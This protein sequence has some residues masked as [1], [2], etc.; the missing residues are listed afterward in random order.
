[1][2]DYTGK[3]QRRTNKLVEM[4]GLLQNVTLGLKQILTTVLFALFVLPSLMDLTLA[5]TASM[6]TALDAFTKDLT[7]V[8]PFENILPNNPDQYKPITCYKCGAYRHRDGDDFEK[9]YKECKDLDTSRAE[10]EDCPT[11]V[12]GQLTNATCRVTTNTIT[13]QVT[14]FSRGC[15]FLLPCSELKECYDSTKKYSG[16][17]RSCCKETLCNSSPP[18]HSTWSILALSL[19]IKFCFR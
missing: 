19:L 15:S 14:S 11:F 7:T 18:T 8:F 1:M 3:L 10:T 5:H 6:V 17:C 13:S 9:K 16:V 2:C 12:A 4:G